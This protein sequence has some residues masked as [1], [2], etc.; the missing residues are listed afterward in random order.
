MWNENVNPVIRQIFHT[1]ELIYFCVSILGM[2]GSL[3]WTTMPTHL[4][5]AIGSNI[6]CQYANLSQL[7]NRLHGYDKMSIVMSEQ[8]LAKFKYLYHEH[9]DNSEVNL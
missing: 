8:V 5:E 4:F 2:I 1:N 7:N 3:A 6:G 9:N